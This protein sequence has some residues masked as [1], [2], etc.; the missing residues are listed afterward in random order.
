[1]RFSSD[2]L[3]GG[4][5]LLFFLTLLGHVPERPPCT[6]VLTKCH[7]THGPGEWHDI[8][9]WLFLNNVWLQSHHVAFKA[10]H[11]LFVTSDFTISVHWDIMIF[12]PNISKSTLL[13]ASEAGN[14]SWRLQSFRSAMSPELIT[15]GQLHLIES[16]PHLTYQAGALLTPCHRWVQKGFCHVFMVPE[17]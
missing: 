15:C 1:M 4:F 17:K 14:N 3:M 6:H 2:I 10:S 11:F 12:P 7:L 5:T 13:R 8:S 9:M 16:I